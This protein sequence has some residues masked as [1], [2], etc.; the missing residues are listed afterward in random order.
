MTAREAKRQYRLKEWADRISE[1]SRSGLTIKAWCAE[2]GVSARRYYY[3]LNMVREYAAQF[4]PAASSREALPV[5]VS[6][7]P[8]AMTEPPSGWARAEVAEPLAAPGVTIE[9][10]GCRVT[11][12]LDT[13]TDLLLRVCRTL[14]NL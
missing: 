5:P 1:R 10:G 4:L 6:A 3:W 14:K 7:R 2:N 9:V 12:T 8:A 13:D 11:A